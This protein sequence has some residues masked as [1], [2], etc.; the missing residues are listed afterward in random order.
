MKNTR[1][2]ILLGGILLIGAVFLLLDF[3][4]AASNTQTG[5]LIFTTDMGENMPVHMQRRDKISI[6]LV[7]EGPLVRALQKA[8]PEQIGK[9]G[10][11]ESDVVQELESVYQHPVLVVKVSEPDP[12]WT[13]FFAMSQFSI[14]AAYGSDGDSTFMEGVEKTHTSI[15]KKDVSNMYA[16]Y[17]FNDRSWGLISRPG[18]HQFL[19]DYLAQE[20]VAVLKELYHV[21]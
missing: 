20:I 1:S 19:A 4:V 3:R 5:K 14:H 9:A 17:E 15:A 13:P 8:L 2:W 21:P 10:I 12:I 11:G 6:V 7:G 18:Y 16:E